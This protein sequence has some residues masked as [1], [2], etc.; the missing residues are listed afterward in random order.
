M[1][2][3]PESNTARAFLT[4]QTQGRNHTL[5]ARID[6]A[7]SDG[8]VS[9]EMSAFIDALA[10]LLAAST[11]VKFERASLGSNIR[12]PATWSGL[13]SWGTGGSGDDEQAPLFYSFTGK[14]ADGRRA[15]VEMF[16]RNTA[17]NENWRV[18]TGANADIAAAVAVLEGPEAVWN[19]I[20]DLGVFWNQYANQSISQHW[21]G[22]ARK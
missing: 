19:S 8:D 14:S 1:A 13:T 3:L 12:T 9:E 17:P 10:P 20:S 4:Y 7:M 11:F 22:E 5:M 2:P 6:G 16:G 15:R 18:T 21:V